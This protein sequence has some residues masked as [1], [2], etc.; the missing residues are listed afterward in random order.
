MT[1]ILFKLIEHTTRL[2]N[3]CEFLFQMKE[4]EEGSAEWMK[5]MKPMGNSAMPNHRAATWSFTFSAHF[6]LLITTGLLLLYL[7]LILWKIVWVYRCRHCNVACN[8]VTSHEILYVITPINE[9]YYSTFIHCRNSDFLIG[10][11]VPR[12]T[13]LWRNKLWHHYHGVISVV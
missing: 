6:I 7:I 8:I 4:G 11:F 9:Y 1:L 2:N 10:W 13:G 3:I 12:D 5:E